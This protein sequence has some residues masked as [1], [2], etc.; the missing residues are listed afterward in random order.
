[1][2]LSIHTKVF[3]TLLLACVLVL[4][5]TQA[6]VHWSLQR[7]LI[8]LADA[9]EQARLTVIAE[10][11]TEIY[12]RDESWAPLRASPRLWVGT[13]LGRDWSAEGHRGRGG[14][15]EHAPHWMRRLLGP[16]RNGAGRQVFE[17]PPRHVLEEDRQG[18]GVPL[19][20]RLMLLDAD[21]ALVYGRAELLPATRRFPLE[22]DGMP[23]G[24]LA[25]IA[26]PPIPELTDLHFVDRQGGRLWLIAMAM[27]A[28]AA[29]LAYPLSSRLIRP[30]QGFQNTARRLAAGDYSA[31]VSVGGDDEIARLGRDINALA[32]ALERNEQ[33]RRAWV[34]DISHEL[35]TPIALLRAHLEAL[36][37]G[38]RPLEQD[39]VDRLHA[40][41][42]RLSRLVEDLNDLAMTDLGA[43]A[44]RKEEIDLAEVL[45]DEID[46]FQTRFAAASLT[47]KLDNSLARGAPLHADPDRMSQLFRNLLQNSLSYTDPGGALRVTLDV[48]PG[49]GY[50]VTFEDTAPGVPTQDL[51]RLF[52][53][54]YRVEASRSRHTGGA[55]LGLAIAKNVV[56]AHGGTIEARAAAAGGCE[57]RIDLPALES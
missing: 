15:G 7:G 40:D 3:L 17:W 22:L 13:L 48:R 32:G 50:R 41:L 51:P 43:L 44:Y 34:A 24:Q 33:A 14:H 55:G 28:L 16:S 53:R 36:Q 29:A 8:E 19:A 11:L 42:L 25:L 18:Q 30:V 9:R 23:I 38:V 20:L 2:A 31:R 12:A 47:L 45:A 4:L 35:R 49:G 54:L 6:V 52:D 21:G 56:V 10:Q 37:D 57:I 27:L 26:G 39:E 46:A 5:G 1:M